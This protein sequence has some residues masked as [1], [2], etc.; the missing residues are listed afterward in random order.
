MILEFIVKNF[1]SFKDEICLS[2]EAKKKKIQGHETNIIVMP[3]GTKIIRFLSLYG[4]NASGKSNLIAAYENMTTFWLWRPQSSSMPINGFVPFRFDTETVT[5]SCHFELK[6]YVD[7]LKY[8]YLLDVNSKEVES[9]SLYYY[10]STRK[11]ML[12][13]RTTIEGIT[14]IEF[15][16]ITDI[17]PSSLLKKEINMRCLSNMSVMSALMG[18]NIDIKPIAAVKEWIRNKVAPFLSINQPELGYTQTFIDKDDNLRD[19]L[20]S[21][22]K[23]ADFNIVDFVT[24][25]RRQSVP[26]EIIPFIERNERIPAE[27]RAEIVSSGGFTLPTIEF[28]HSVENERGIETYPLSEEY[29]SSGTINLV[30]LESALYIHS[31]QG[32]FFYVDEI[33]HSLHP[34]LIKYVIEKFIDE[35]DNDAQLLIATHYTPLLDEVDSLFRSDSIWF[36]DKGKNGSTSIYPLYCEKGSQRF[37]SFQAAYLEGLFKRLI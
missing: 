27:E 36:T 23:E 1:A 13:D 10:T 17:R 21:V 9:E 11:K 29:E 4:R 32:G 30:E 8:W 24:K 2:F 15:N 34:A 20:K 18:V 35:K 12:F 37:N 6:F 28:I 3:D 7:G 19:H 14:R 31:K 22:M 25:T 33:E 26:K 16:N 5:K